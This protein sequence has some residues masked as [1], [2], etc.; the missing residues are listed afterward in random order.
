MKE[1]KIHT[2]SYIFIDV[3]QK[4]E[5][6]VPQDEKFAEY[7]GKAWL[8]FLTNSSNFVSVDLA[9]GNGYLP[10]FNHAQPTPASRATNASTPPTSGN[11]PGQ[12]VR[13]GS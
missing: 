6:L 4:I 7:E 2:Y 10:I 13:L 1:T 3:K 11:F 5:F 12:G 9:G 8:R